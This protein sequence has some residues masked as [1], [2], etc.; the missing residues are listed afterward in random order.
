MYSPDYR[1]LDPAQIRQCHAAGIRVMPWTVNDKAD[2]L[3]LIDRGVD[4]ITTDY[5]DRLAKVLRSR[6]IEF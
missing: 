6:G 4:G 5:P 2:W 3:R 1:F